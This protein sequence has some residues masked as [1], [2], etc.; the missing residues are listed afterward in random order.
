MI[1]REAL[2]QLLE[3]PDINEESTI[4]ATRQAFG[5]GQLDTVALYLE[6]DNNPYIAYHTKHTARK[7]YKF[8]LSDTLFQS[9]ESPE[10]YIDL[11]SAMIRYG[12]VYLWEGSQTLFATQRPITSASQCW[13]NAKHIIADQEL[14]IKQS[15]AH[16]GHSLE[17]FVIV[18]SGRLLKLLREITQDTTLAQDIV[19][20][21]QEPFDLERMEQISHSF[22]C[23]NEWKM[24]IIDPT[25]DC[26]HYLASNPLIANITFECTDQDHLKKLVDT[27]QQCAHLNKIE[28][29]VSSRHEDITLSDS[30]CNELVLDATSWEHLH[31]N[32]DQLPNI[33]RLKKVEIHGA[34]RQKA[35][36]DSPTITHLTVHQNITD[37]IILTSRANIT[38]LSLLD[39]N[40]FITLESLFEDYP[41]LEEFHTDFHVALSS[42]VKPN[43]K[44]H[45][46]SLLFAPR[47]LSDKKNPFIYLPNVKKL[48]V[49]IDY[50]KKCPASLSTL[51]LEEITILGH[52]D[53]LTQHEL[54][55][56]IPKTI[57]KITLTECVLDKKDFLVL[58]FQE[59]RSVLIRHC[60]DWKIDFQKT[61]NIKEIVTNNPFCSLLLGSNHDH[62]EKIVIAYK[63]YL[64]NK[65]ANASEIYCSQRQILIV[66]PGTH[67]V[68]TIREKLLP[69]HITNPEHYVFNQPGKEIHMSSCILN[70]LSFDE[71]N[72]IETI[73][74]DHTCAIESID[75]RLCKKLKKLNIFLSNYTNTTLF[76]PDSHAIEMINIQNRFENGSLTIKN[77]EMLAQYRQLAVLNIMNA[78]AI[79]PAI[80]QKL[81]Y[82]HLYQLSISGVSSDVEPFIKS[83]D[84]PNLCRLNLRLTP[85][86]NRMPDM[87]IRNTSF[88]SAPDHIIILSVAS[89]V[90]MDIQGGRFV[91]YLTVRNLRS[92]STIKDM[93]NLFR[94]DSVNTTH[95]TINGCNVVSLI[96]TAS[97]QAQY[98][99]NIK[100]SKIMNYR[101]R[102]DDYESKPT[103]NLILS[104]AHIDN[105]TILQATV[106]IE[107]MQ[108]STIQL[109]AM[110]NSTI[111]LPD[112][113]DKQSITILSD[114]DE[115]Q[116]LHHADGDVTQEEHRHQPTITLTKRA[117]RSFSLRQSSTLDSDTANPE[118]H[119][120]S[121][122]FHCQILSNPEI[123]ANH[124]RINVITHCLYDKH[125]QTIAFP[126]EPQFAWNMK[127]PTSIKL[128]KKNVSPIKNETIA[129]LRETVA[130]TNQVAISYIDGAFENKKYIPLITGADTPIINLDQIAAIYSDYDDLANLKAGIL[131]NENQSQAFL[132][133]EN[134]P[135]GKT[136]KFYFLYTKI[137][138]QYD[139]PQTQPVLDPELKK[140]VMKA[141]STLKPH[142]PLQRLLTS[143]NNQQTSIEEKTKKLVT[144]FSHY[145]AISLSLGFLS[146]V[147]MHDLDKFL[148]SI[149]QRRG[150]CRHRAQ[151]C[152]LIALLTGVPC[153]MIENSLHAF[154]E[155]LTQSK[156]DK[157]TLCWQKYDLGGGIPRVTIDLDEKDSA[158]HQAPM[159]TSSQQTTAIRSNVHSGKIATS[160][161]AL[162]SAQSSPAFEAYKKLFSDLIKPQIIQSLDEIKKPSALSPL[163]QC[164]SSDD[165]TALTRH[166]FINKTPNEKIIYI[167]SP[168]DFKILFESW[169]VEHGIRKKSQGPLARLLANENNVEATILVNWSQ[170]SATDLAAYQSIID[171]EPT[172]FGTA[173][174][175]QVKV[176]GLMANQNKLAD[177][178][179]FLS[180]CQEIALSAPLLQTI[181]AL[182]IIEQPS[183]TPLEINLFGLPDWKQMLFGKVILTGNGI[184]FKEGILFEAIRHKR[185]LNIINPPADP[186]FNEWLY[187]LKTTKEWFFNNESISIPNECQLFTIKQPGINHH[188]NVKVS[189]DKH[190]SDKHPIFLSAQ[191]WHT[192]FEETIYTGQ[193]GRTVSGLLN[194]YNE[195]THYFLIH[196]MITESM[197]QKMIAT[198]QT[199]Y[200]HTQFTF[201]LS[202]G[203]TIEHVA[204]REKPPVTTALPSE[205]AT[206]LQSNAT[207][208]ISNDSDFLIKCLLKEKPD[209]I[210]IHLK[211]SSDASDIIFKSTV[212]NA[213][214]N[215]VYFN[216]ELKQPFLDLIE[217]KTVILEGALSIPL[218]QALYPLIHGQKNI[219]INGNEFT[220][221]G[222]LLIVLS[223]NQTKQFS[224]QEAAR[225]QSSLQDYR[226]HIP[227]A[228]QAIFDQLIKFYEIARKISL[229]GMGRPPHLDYHYERLLSS[230]RAI[231][232]QRHVHNPLKNVFHYDFPKQSKE[233]AY[234]AVVSKWFFAKDD[235]S[236]MNHLRLKKLIGNM[237]EAELRNQLTSNP[238]HIL[239]CFRGKALCALL[240]KHWDDILLKTSNGFPI[241]STAS[242]EQIIIAINEDALKRTFD[243]TLAPTTTAATLTTTLSTSAHPLETRATQQ[244][245]QILNDPTSRIIFLKG[246]P[247]VG[248]TY[249]VR[250]LKKEL[251]LKKCEF[252][253]ELLKWL[254]YPATDKTPVLLVDEAN[255]LAPGSLD[256]LKGLA[257]GDIYHDGKRYPL[258][259][260]HKIIL[261]G[262]PEHFPG[263]HYHDFIRDQAVTI[264]VKPPTVEFLRA[265]LNSQLATLPASRLESSITALIDIY[266][267]IQQFNPAYLYSLRD[268]ENVSTRFLLCINK[269]K[270][271]A[272]ALYLAARHEFFG[273][274]IDLKQRDQ[275]MDYLNGEIL[276]QSTSSSTAAP[277]HPDMITIKAGLSY[278]REMVNVIESIEEDLSI[279]DNHLSG[280]HTLPY[281]QGILIESEVGIGKSTLLKAL[282][283]K[284][285]FTNAESSISSTSLSSQKQYI[286]LNVIP[287][288]PL[289]PE[290]SNTSIKNKLVEAY[291][292]GQVVILNE[293]NL[294]Q[295]LEIFLNQLLSGEDPTTVKEQSAPI[296]PIPG[297][298]V[299]ASQNS[300]ASKGREAQSSALK[301]RMHVHYIEPFSTESLLNI[302]KCNNVPEPDNFVR[303]FCEQ[304]KTNPERT[305]MRLFYTAIK[306]TISP[307]KQT[308]QPAIWYK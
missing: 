269:E 224:L 208:A 125:H 274:F 242:I 7:Q 20:K 34:C 131:L 140:Q 165:L 28:I 198:V 200:P 257:R 232:K 271:Y 163:I 54:D 184:E 176:I 6:N 124:Y 156:H 50:L 214:D 171:A 270:D 70:E 119:I 273:N 245:R 162:L 122:K 307:P 154:V 5:P 159:T 303:A 233:Y 98:H 206:I 40:S 43:Y 174:P 250:H 73:D 217:G 177:N 192:L 18:D 190:P 61:P 13:I 301:N 247:G 110:I 78:F 173:I 203:A 33:P 53:P 21:F 8:I 308:Q 298:M 295:S 108:Q 218:Y 151:G 31:I 59:L 146:N 155:M 167:H 51:P 86:L 227:T 253:K 267:A 24:L 69:D 81:S 160:P 46:L 128:N 133:F 105:I 32:H 264:Y 268:L 94:V 52:G 223:D 209:A 226:E 183:E 84:A 38:H 45:S 282:L 85:D 153:R 3:L 62:L 100:N 248:K 278:P 188:N 149:I 262:N 187:R 272:K 58:A 212:A 299:F 106:N 207:V 30:F 12:E 89:N 126:Y 158:F 66:T 2:Y 202:E 292:K 97:D 136:I 185:S 254:T 181:K 14:T 237:K 294:N 10:Q 260:K 130:N 115:E 193:E 281:K 302:A 277:T 275:F 215:S 25:L 63:T 49:H 1:S 42:K 55:S 107:T 145:D 91:H 147:F 284:Q 109:I 170:F 287:E 186:A 166:L 123:V 112:T 101:I 204:S 255:L 4:Q 261:T 240:D 263:R 305:N 82:P 230:I 120:I 83:L 152:L 41:N 258:S 243:I 68:H 142:H 80:H 306:E 231:K 47:N 241:L 138:N 75:L 36:I 246:E 15:L 29:R 205:P 191:E 157:K 65:I 71:K 72:V 300:G 95:F 293:L 143:L 111:Q 189:L 304:K 117:A 168:S 249:T 210:V 225:H 90:H 172:L 9:T 234:F 141:F 213:Q 279:R 87:N 74:I 67:A 92:N 201:Y 244:L 180:R 195:S 44:I 79:I 127:Q 39:K 22:D 118:K 276:S 289:N 96:S 179:S 169:S 64:K 175:S 88:F 102:N 129:L 16:Q 148:E 251:N 93:P 256:F 178:L 259:D 104:D 103:L 161:F 60:N 23:V 114:Q 285:G 164:D 219:R 26:L 211:P 236:P 196:G 288:D 37:N 290:A 199:Q 139:Y 283:E 265:L 144:Y 135:E 297:F 19:A 228:D 286:E 220:I 121:G 17:E 197:W 280:L 239:N 216:S 235:S 221:K 222:R 116:A 48:T 35:I 57:K 229:T 11:V 99:V 266:H 76:L 132:Y 77:P 238:W 194:N 137:E 296:K 291:R 56:A 134:L 252:P 113:A 182:P 27:L 150:V